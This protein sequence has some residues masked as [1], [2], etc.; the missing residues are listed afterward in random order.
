MR[1]RAPLLG[2]VACLA[3]CAGS[4][5]VGTISALE[6]VV[7]ADHTPRGD[8]PRDLLGE[9]REALP[10]HAVE[11]GLLGRSREGGRRLLVRAEIEDFPGRGS[12]GLGQGAPWIEAGPI[13]V[14]YTVT[15][16]DGKTVAA[17]TLTTDPRDAIHAPAD[18]FVHTQAV[19]FVR[20]LAGR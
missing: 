16:D 17:T 2:L 13:S 1:I 15:D 7:V 5:D 11:R 19:A 20:W 4:A 8:V 12:G 3:G 9:L 6:V 10:R 14:A 18:P